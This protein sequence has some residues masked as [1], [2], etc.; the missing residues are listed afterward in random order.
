LT[1]AVVEFAE[2]KGNDKGMYATQNSRPR[3]GEGQRTGQA[4]GSHGNDTSDDKDAEDPGD[5]N[6]N[7]KAKK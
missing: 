3:D 1:D 7:S 4:E 5:R 6:F 2:D